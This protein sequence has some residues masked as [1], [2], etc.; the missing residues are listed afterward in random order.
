MTTS[1]SKL[2]RFFLYF[3]IGS[4]ILG[5]LLGILVVLRNQWG[6]FELRVILT[7]V[8]FAVASLCGLACEL[9]RLPRGLNLLP[10]AGL[11]LTLISTG[12]MLL[13]IWQEVNDDEFWKFT[14]SSC[15]LTVAMVHVCLLSI[16]PLVGSYKWVYYIA[17]QVI[18][19]LALI[20]IYEIFSESHLDRDYQFIGVL[21]IIDVAL[22]LTIPLL[23]RLGKSQGLVKTTQDPTVQRSVAAIDEEIDSL[24]SQIRQ[25]EK[26]KL[27][28]S[29]SAATDTGGRT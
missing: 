25:L 3:L 18:F 12:L 28:L 14:I 6:W 27:E 9:A 13:G 17:V 26:L 19:G 5:A 24:R 7:T 20:L 11:V 10:R 21:A 15:I 4:V 16:M 23:Y 1:K 2:H 8:T 29:G 22:T